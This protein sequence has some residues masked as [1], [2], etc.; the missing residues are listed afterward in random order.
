MYGTQRCIQITPTTPAFWFRSKER[1][2]N[3]V[4]FMWYILAILSKNNSWT[5]YILRESSSR[6][7]NWMYV[8]HLCFNFTCDVSSRHTRRNHILS[9]LY[10]INIKYLFRSRVYALV[11]GGGVIIRR[12]FVALKYSS[13]STLA[14]LLLK[15]KKKL[16]FFIM[17]RFFFFNRI[18]LNAHEYLKSC[19][20]VQYKRPNYAL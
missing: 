9:S 5:A 20:W 16:A 18:I 11:R 15:K 4:I 13:H 2:Y 17:L 7:N 1:N 12:F 19:Y 8:E 3:Y 6:S 14:L 10:A